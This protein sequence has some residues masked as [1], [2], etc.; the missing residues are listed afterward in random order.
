MHLGKLGV[1]PKGKP[2]GGLQAER[3]LRDSEARA[4]E[5]NYRRLNYGMRI[6]SN[7]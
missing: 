2:R 6:F 3:G 5:M 1:F 4:E 7:I